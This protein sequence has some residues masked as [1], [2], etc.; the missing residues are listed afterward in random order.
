MP[1]LTDKEKRSQQN[2]R[3]REANLEAIRE[4]DR[5]YREKNRDQ[6]NAKIRAME[7]HKDPKTKAYRTEYREQNREQ[8]RQWVTN[9]R[10]RKRMEILEF[11]GGV[12]VRCGFDDWRALQIDHVNGNGISDR[13]KNK[14]VSS[15]HKAIRLSIE[16]GEKKYQLLC[17]N[18]N[19]IK[20]HKNK[21]HRKPKE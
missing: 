20:R 6:I 16:K 1:E 3:Y 17:T 2:K 18:C 9:H 5:L 15:Y 4:K 8:T 13:K 10:T 14:S 19:Q 12:C 21:E 7:R 11:M